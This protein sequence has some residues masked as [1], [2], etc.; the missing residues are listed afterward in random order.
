MNIMN[1]R[2]LNYASAFPAACGGVSEH[3]INIQLIDDSSRLAARRINQLF[4]AL[5]WIL[6]SNTGLFAQPDNALWR[7]H[8]AFMDGRYDDAISEYQANIDG[9]ADWAWYPEMIETVRKRK[10]LGDITPADTQRIIAVFSTKVIEYT[11]SGVFISDDVTP[12]K[13]A[14]WVIAFGVMQRTIEAWSN[15]NFTLDFDTI[16]STVSVEKHE[17]LSPNPSRYNNLE[18]WHLKNMKHYDSFAT[19]SKLISPGRGLA[20]A[21]AYLYYEI[22][23][24]SRGMFAVNGL[25]HGFP[26]LLHEFFH[27]IEWVSGVSN[28]VAHGYRDGLRDSF[29]DWTG[30][31]EYDYYRWH[32]ETTIPEG[33]W[34]RLRHTTRW[35]PV[36]PDTVAWKEIH[37]M[38]VD[39]PIHD[40]LVAD[41]LVYDG[42]VLINQ[43]FPDSGLVFLNQALEL[44][45]MH[46][47]GLAILHDYYRN[48]APDEAKAL[49]AKE[50]LQLIRRISDFSYWYPEND[51]LGEVIG[52]WH[53]EDVP[54]S[55]DF[56]EW[57]VSEYI[58]GNGTYDFSFYYT[59][60]W[61][62]IDIDSV[63]LLQDVSR[64]AEDNHRGFSGHVK[65]DITYRLSVPEYDPEASYTLRAKIKGSGGVKSYGQIH[66]NKVSDCAAQSVT[67]TVDLCEGDSVVVGSNAYHSTGSYTDTLVT[68]SGCDSIISTHL[69]VH[70]LPS[71]VEITGLSSPEASDT[72]FYSVPISSDISYYWSIENGNILWH[73]SSYTAVIHWNNAG[74]G[75]V[76]V[77]AEDQYGC[78]GD[79]SR[80]VIVIGN[81]GTNSI[82][83]KGLSIY[84]NPARDHLF[85]EIGDYALMEEHSVQIVNQLGQVVYQTDIDR[86]L[87]RLSISDWQ[88]R[89]LHIIQ[90]QDK[91]GNIVASGKIVLE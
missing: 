56:V 73:P 15:G 47:G 48:V 27:S 57:D 81:T 30:E 82:A 62:A 33:G 87:Y 59:Y 25:N 91:A 21:Q 31:T 1:H 41:T 66:L 80:L 69:T 78:S 37:D 3:K 9:G 89:G 2:I 50:K 45:P 17:G 49:E 83:T 84:P 38:Y 7:G 42:D 32:F 53:R 76:S 40:R 71:Y 10:E 34:K 8:A 19:L 23:G 54:F 79:T 29:P 74:T 75:E 85:I 65:T 72:I 61:K 46:T 60:S 68:L 51:S 70:L 5:L 35:I 20:A 88:D 86:T 16:S 77:V 52:F 39:I 64:I 67:R 24:P 11:D 28:G 43:G 90:V 26:T 58:T 44:S 18:Y 63:S 22:Y 6:F 13:K 36:Q 12:E 4:L 55:W 14:E